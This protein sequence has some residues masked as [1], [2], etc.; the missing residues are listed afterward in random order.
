[1]D[2][3]GLTALDVAIGLA[4]LFFLLS[5]V[6]ASINEGIAGLF[7]WRAQE[8]E[9]AM[10][11]YLAPP[12]AA[13][14]EAREMAGAVAPGQ[15]AE[16]APEDAALVPTLPAS[17]TDRVKLLFAERRIS[18]LIDDDRNYWP[19][20]WPFKGKR[21]KKPRSPSYLPA[22]AVAL[23]LLD[24]FTGRAGTDS[25]DLVAPT[26]AVAEK[27]PIEPLRTV[28]LDSLA[29]G[30]TGLDEIREDVER[31]FD[32]VMDRCAGW[33][34]RRTQKWILVIATLLVVGLNVNTFTVAD[35][36]AKEDALRASVVEQAGKRVAQ[37]AEGSDETTATGAIAEQ[38]DDVRELGLP[39]GWSAENRPKKTFRSWAGTI[40][41]WL[42]TIAAI[43]LGAPFWFDVLGR[44]ARLRNSG[45][46]E[47]TEKDPKRGALDSDETRTR[48]TA[49]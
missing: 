20:P 25:K 31:S 5:T 13:E 3:T 17:E 46:R 40:L 24:T 33:Y 39:M 8:L 32:A 15:D 38:V 9:K 21:R 19:R 12:T 6:C 23:T 35:R 43:S 28:V 4:F 1:M 22:R 44:F 48:P 42:A 10:R 2:L 7:G 11:E 41:G 34:K 29:A 18:V 47:G 27:I 30:R 37:P 49:T 14:T 36:L 26:T 45:N 16:P